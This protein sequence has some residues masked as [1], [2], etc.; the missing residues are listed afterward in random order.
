MP[1][2]YRILILLVVLILLAS[3]FAIHLLNSGHGLIQIPLG[4]VARREIK[5]VVNTNGVI[6][7]MARSELY[8][9]VDGFVVQILKQEGSEVRQGQPLMQMESESIQTALA[10]AKAGLLQEKRQERAML[11]W[12]PKE[13][14]AEVDA[15]IAES[16]LQLRQAQKELRDEESLHSKGATTG[17]AVENLRNKRD[18]LQL[19]VDASKQK[20]ND[21]QQRYSPEDKQLEHS[22]VAE[23]AKQVAV[24]EN[25]LQMESITSPKNGLI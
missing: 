24:L 8:A 20:R 21:L 13:E 14:I 16:E 7:P 9:P 1:R 17:A 11:A 5:V 23:L 6:D 10:E 25:Q 18:L 4:R 22:K 2:K 15:A 12:P 19:K 3:Y